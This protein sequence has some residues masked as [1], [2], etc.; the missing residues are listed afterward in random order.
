MDDPGFWEGIGGSTVLLNGW[1]GGL[2]T[3]LTG[4]GE[5]GNVAR[6]LGIGSSERSEQNTA[7][8]SP[9]EKFL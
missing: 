4:G 6:I 8:G 7:G 5:A 3:K 2:Q 1:G 9:P